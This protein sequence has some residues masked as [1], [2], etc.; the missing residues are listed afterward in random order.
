MLCS[1]LASILFP[2]HADAVFEHFSLKNLGGVRRRDAYATVLYFCH[3]VLAMAK[4]GVT[5]HGLTGSPMAARSF[6]AHPG[7]L[8]HRSSTLKLNNF[9]VVCHKYQEECPDGDVYT[10][11]QQTPYLKNEEVWLVVL[12]LI[13][14]AEMHGKGEHSPP[15]PPF[16]L[17]TLSNHHPLV[18]R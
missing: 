9:S 14:R 18:K 17:W 1:E 4:V 10:W 11:W 15:P 16:C 2:Q 5:A 3:I 12:C 13:P 7:R 6:H 8:F